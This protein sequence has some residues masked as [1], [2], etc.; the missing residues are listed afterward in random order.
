MQLEW[1]QPIILAKP[2][3]MT[4]ADTSLLL[5]VFERT[6]DMICI[7]DKEGWFRQVNQAVLHTLGYSREELL[8]RPVAALIHPDDLERTRLKRND[9]LN[10]DPLINF[11]NRYISKDG[12][13]VWLQWTSV[14]IPEKEIVFAIAK[15]ITA[16]KKAELEIEENFKKYKALTAHFKHLVEEDRQYVSTALHEELGQLATVLKLHFEWL[17]TLP[18]LFDNNSQ[19]LIEQGMTAAQ[20]LIDKIR[21][22]SYAISPAQIDDLGLDTAMRS[23]CDEFVRMAGLPCKYVSSFEE[24]KLTREIKLD[25]FRICQEALTNILQY[26]QSTQVS[27]HLV[28]RKTRIEL[29]IRDNGGGVKHESKQSFGLKNMRRRAHS[30]NGEFD[31]K[32]KR[33]EGTTVSIRVAT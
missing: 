18:L 2:W 17:S 16:Q 32:T 9:L 33:S 25:L 28:Q 5:A 4:T 12:S 14:Y 10:N 21:K 7:V 6:P 27:V 26:G 23:L 3:P 31:V 30:I 29:V 22:L 15:N 11:Q 19:A 13:V 8:A 24:D 1:L 20:I